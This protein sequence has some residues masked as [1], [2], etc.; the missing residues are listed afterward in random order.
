MPKKP[1]RNSR[2]PKGKPVSGKDAKPKQKGTTAMSL[3]GGFAR[4]TETRI[5]KIY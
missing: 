3:A 4:I 2:K 5:R 1:K